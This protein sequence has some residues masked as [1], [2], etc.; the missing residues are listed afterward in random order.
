MLK[1]G[2]SRKDLADASRLTRRS[3]TNLLN[4]H[5]KSVR[6]RSRV[7][8][9]MQVPIWS[10]VE[11]FMARREFHE[12]FGVDPF[13]ATCREL[14][15][16]ALKLRLVSACPNH[17]KPA[18]VRLLWAR[19]I[20]SEHERS[21]IQPGQSSF[22][23]APRPPSG[24]AAASERIAWLSTARLGAVSF[25]KH[26]RAEIA[27]ARR[28]EHGQGTEWIYGAIAVKETQLSLCAERARLYDLEIAE[29][30]RTNRAAVRPA[31]DTSLSRA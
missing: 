11:A 17:S 26:L 28:Q 13:S 9:A 5:S 6:A 21:K 8:W 31:R 19:I 15:V 25:Q 23:S 20:P 29:L 14:A 4:D 22:D 24:P 18:L 16:V 2:W 30:K 3:L 27:L 12:R 10:S 7:E 1:I